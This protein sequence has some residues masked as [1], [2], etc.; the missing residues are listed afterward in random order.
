MLGDRLSNNIEQSLPRDIHDNLSP[1][2][3]SILRISGSSG[4]CE[5]RTVA[6]WRNANSQVPLKIAIETMHSP[7]NRM[8]HPITE[9]RVDNQN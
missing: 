3:R 5:M 4:I 6:V 7:A 8:A 1:V 9:W 2:S